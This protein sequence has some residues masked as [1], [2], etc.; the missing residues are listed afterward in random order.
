M[1]DV[2]FGRI[3]TPDYNMLHELVDRWKHILGNKKV[4]HY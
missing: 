3:C 1:W 2:D 4:T